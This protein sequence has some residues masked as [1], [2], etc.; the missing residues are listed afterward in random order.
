MD[1]REEELLPQLINAN[2]KYL[3]SWAIED[4]RNRQVDA[5]EYLFYL[6]NAVEAITWCGMPVSQ[7]ALED[8]IRTT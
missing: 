2:Q 8:R 6:K 3:L 4:F 1:H 7:T 5:G